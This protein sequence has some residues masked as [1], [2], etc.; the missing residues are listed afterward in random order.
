MPV[1]GP[2]I[3]PEAGLGGGQLAIGDFFSPLP[4]GK[5]GFSA[6]FLGVVR[7]A[8]VESEDAWTGAD[9]FLVGETCHVVRAKPKKGK[10]KEKGNGRQ[11]LTLDCE[12]FEH[13]GEIPIEDFEM[14][15]LLSTARLHTEVAG[16]EVDVTWTGEGYLPE[17]GA[18][19]G[20][21]PEGAVD[22][23]ASAGR[24]ASAEGM[25]LGNEVR[26][27][28][29]DFCFSFS[30]MVEGAGGYAYVGGLA[31]GFAVPRR[32][33]ELS[34]EGLRARACSSRTRTLPA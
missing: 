13:E 30:F 1:P 29:E 32:A 23:G 18:G 27:A 17:G 33:S 2:S 16:S 25:I 19:A 24:W 15:P 6:F 11:R 21:Y 10:S 7:G 26:S 14:D 3:T 34:A 4:G 20:F 22:A 31:E 9:M 8:D 5:D 12:R 28:D